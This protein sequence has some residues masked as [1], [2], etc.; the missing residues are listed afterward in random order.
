MYFAPNGRLRT[1]LS[2]FLQRCVKVILHGLLTDVHL[3]CNIII[4]E[5]QFSGKSVNRT[6]FVGHFS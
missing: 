3:I 5:S 6:P 4:G 1:V 2:K